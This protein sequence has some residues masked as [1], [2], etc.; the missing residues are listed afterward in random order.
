[1]KSS[2]YKT[3]KLIV[4]R[5]INSGATVVDVEKCMAEARATVD[6]S[7]MTIEEMQETILR[8]VLTTI[9]N[10]NKFYSV[11]RRK[12]LFANSENCKKAYLKQLIKNAKND[13]A[14]LEKL[15]EKL[16]KQ[17][18]IA[19]IDGQ[20]A[21]DADTMEIFEEMTEEELVEMLREEAEEYA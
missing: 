6:F 13:M 2:I 15:V 10:A 18:D 8:L 7:D 5:Y 20:M 3:C 17:V 4:S 9:L 14:R 11:V 16:N 19:E 21:F 12:G 1:M